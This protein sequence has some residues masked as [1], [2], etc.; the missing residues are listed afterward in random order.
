[1]NRKII[2]LL[3]SHILFVISLLVFA[4]AMGAATFIE[5]DFG[6]EKAQN[7]IYKAW[8]FEAVLILITVNLSASI[9][10]KKMY[11]IQKL[12]VFILHIAFIFMLIGAGITRYFGYEGT[13]H[14]REK[15]EASEIITKNRGLI[16]QQNNFQ[17]FIHTDFDRLN[18]LNKNFVIGNKK[19]NIKTL[20][21][22]QN[23]YPAAVADNQGIPIIGFIAEHKGYRN[24]SY[25]GIN[26][27]QSI[28]EFVCSF[29]KDNN[30]SDVNFFLQND[31]IFI[32]SHKTDIVYLDTNRNSQII[33]KKTAV[34]LKNKGYYIISNIKLSVKEILTRGRI[35]AKNIDDNKRKISA[36]AE[37]KI[38]HNNKSK[39]IQIWEHI[40]GLH[41]TVTFD[42]TTLNF[43]YGNQTINLPFSI[44]LNR[45][46]LSRYP[47]SKSPSS[48]S[49]YVVIKE[50]N[51]ADKSFHIYMNNI[52]QMNG[53]RFFQSSY[54]PDEKGTIL[55]VNYDIWGTSVT[56]FAYFLLFLGI[57]LNMCC[58]GLFKRL[59]KN[60]ITL[61]LLFLFAFYNNNIVATPTS[62]LPKSVVSK[63]HAEEFGKLLIQD[64][65]NRTKPIYTLASDLSR[66]LYRSEFIYGLSPAQIFLEMNIDPKMWV[67]IPIIKIKNRQLK[68]FLNIDNDYIAYNQLVLPNG[69]YLLHK[70]VQNA[71]SKPLVQRSKFDKAVL[72]ADE[73]ANICYAVFSGSFLRVFPKHKNKKDDVWLT[74]Q[75][76][77]KLSYNN[78]NFEN[79]NLLKQYLKSIKYARENNNYDNANSLLKKL[80]EYQKNNATYT[81]PT[82]KQI[83]A[84]LFYYKWNIFKK[85]FPFYVSIGVLFFIL[86]I[87]GIIRNRKI[88]KTVIYIFY[89]LL[90]FGFLLHSVGIILR[91]YISGHAPISN[92]YEVMIF[93]SWVTVLSS[94]VFGKKSDLTASATSILAG[95]TLMVANLSF[96]DPVITNLVPV[97]Q[98]YWLTLHVSVI[99]GS[100]AFLGLSA[101]LGIINQLL[102]ATQIRKQK[103][104]IINIIQ[105]LSEVNSKA[106]NFGLSFL[107]IGTFLGAIWANESWGRYWGW[108]P[109]ETW[110][111]IT[112]IVYTLVTH[113]RIIK[114]VKGYFIFNL[115]A[116]Y[117]I[118]SVLMTYFGVNYYL[119]GLHSYAGGD[120]LTI[121]DFLYYAIISLCILSVLAW[122][123]MRQIQIKS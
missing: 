91:W 63:T 79:N 110:S 65:N 72:K 44:Y 89:I 67:N 17:Q 52:L 31:S 93:I 28:D 49:S 26:Q 50:K 16:I 5:N 123:G 109:K 118:S 2:P 11:K 61:M 53:F 34:L 1:M 71:N 33:A 77:N 55:S 47:G 12:P 80:K 20:Y 69:E 22:Y 66:K 27:T 112:I 99:T 23:A 8:W 13:I 100:Y 36:V 3:S 48:Y 97:L 74:L 14:I 42:S 87:M 56:Y 92:G 4:F 101:I 64:N 73:Q 84:E 102:F 90:I 30:N 85:L 78:I 83:K 114:G 70:L 106:L 59:G 120:S 107:V 57:I 60:K 45:F 35:L 116:L 40:S 10:A 68:D 38:T 96:M 54:D 117:S 122:I 119:A 15:Q 43:N 88:S 95:L 18:K 6:T 98:S 108:D 111:L 29:D 76:I 46:E 51:K 41:N 113:L 32:L 24:F 37:F 75:D 103:S 121:P 81:L 21:Y 9:F 105:H 115:L 58:A 19:F 62:K 104:D 82:D 39:S 86:L 25:I 94:F 7:L